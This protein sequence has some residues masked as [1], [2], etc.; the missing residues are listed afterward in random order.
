MQAY[1]VLRRGGIKDDRI[2]GAHGCCCSEER[3]LC[4]CHR[5]VPAARLLLPPT[6]CCRSSAAALRCCL[7]A[8]SIA[9]AA[10]PL[11]PPAVLMYDDVAHSESNPHPGQLFNA[12]GGPDVYAG[13]T[14][15]SR[16]GSLQLLQSLQKVHS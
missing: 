3:L 6:C 13:I 12:P 4:C 8:L 11:L 10:S 1:Q 7:H 14:I 9:A 2:I 5:R 15:V 16:L